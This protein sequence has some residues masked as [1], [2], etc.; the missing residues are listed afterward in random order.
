MGIHD[1]RR[2][3]SG[4][5]H[6]FHL[7]WI[8]EISRTLNRGLLPPDYYAL[9]EQVAGVTG[10]DVLTLRHPSDD[11]HSSGA[12]V[13]LATSPPK[14]H[15][16]FRAESNLY[17]AK[18]KTVVIRHT[19]GHRIV[20]M[21]EIVSPGN[22]DSKYRLRAF[23]DKAVQVL[24]AGIHLVLVDLFP[25]GPRDP[26]GLH[27]AVWDEIED[28]DFTMPADKPLLEAAYIGGPLPEAFLEPLSV[29][30]DLSDMPLFLS[31]EEY[32]SIPLQATYQAAW[33]AVPKYWQDVLI[34]K[35]AGS[36]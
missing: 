23:V 16:R 15:F 36:S 2:V 33:E 11:S 20:A 9:A 5:F 18:A 32:I 31:P 1:W 19:S 24:R 25:P 4:I 6:H 13:A 26:N 14:V 30:S 7:E 17:A 10:P 22:K 27:R 21:L 29:G 8:A 28:S 35:G 3:E 34:S 12:G